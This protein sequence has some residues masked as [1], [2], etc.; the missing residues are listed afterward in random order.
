MLL[1]LGLYGLL[2]I[3]SRSSPLVLLNGLPP[4]IVVKIVEHKTK[5]RTELAR[6]GIMFSLRIHRNEVMEQKHGRAEFS[7]QGMIK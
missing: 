1:I 2:G 7:Q 3:G 4:F 6:R 5:R